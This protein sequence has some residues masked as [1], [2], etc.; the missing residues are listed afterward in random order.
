MKRKKTVINLGLT[1]GASALLASASPMQAQPATTPAAATTAPST[2]VTAKAPSIYDEIWKYTEL[3]RNDDNPVIESLKFTGRFQLD[4]AQ[5]DADQG[6]HDEWNIRR[7]RLGTK[8]TLFQNFTLH[9]EADLNPQEPRPLYQKLTDAYLAWS[10]SKVFVATVGKQSAGFTMDGMTS[11]KELLAIDRANLAN[12]LWFPEE[13]FPGVTI[14]GKPGHWVYQ[15]GIFSA[16]RADE[17]FG[18]FDGGAFGL[19]TLGY[20]FAGPLHVKQAVLA[21]NYVYNDPDSNNTVSRQL[22]HVG[23]VNF[24]LN[25]GKWGVRTDVSAASGVGKQSDLWGAMVMPYYDITD[26]LQAVARYTY[27]TSDK[28]N[29]V[30]L[31]RYESLAVAG[32]GDTYNE[33]YA[34]LNY[35]FYKHKLKLQTGV[36]YADMQD[37]AND[38]GEYS[39][40]S[41]T[42][43]LR[44]SW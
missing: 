33:I 36:Q 37:R 27:V 21:A 24:N 31:A 35:Y 34:G 30:R 3:Y 7:F 11:S 25:A 18:K 40:W 19:G 16:G 20:D 23:S 8:M 5:V 13:Y 41:W 10:Q 4:Y 2:G 14:S 26:K 17:E 15:A 42:T 43:G 12:N 22:E 1:A 38:G 29:G 39:G 44:I 6:E 28:V 9:A 32:K